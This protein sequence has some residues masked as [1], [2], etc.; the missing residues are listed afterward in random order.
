MNQ[1]NANAY[2]TSL[3]TGKIK[4]HDKAGRS[5]KICRVHFT[6][7]TTTF[8]STETRAGKPNKIDVPDLHI[9]PWK[10]EVSSTS[11]SSSCSSNSSSSSSSSSSSG[12]VN[13]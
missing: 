7:S 10:V 3:G 5:T 8:T 9:D 11:G 13:H 6:H 2:C 12:W 1:L 4:S